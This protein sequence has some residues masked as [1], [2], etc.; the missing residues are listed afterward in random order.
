MKLSQ[1][2]KQ[3]KH[4]EL[5]TMAGKTIYLTNIETLTSEEFGS[6]FKVYFYLEGEPQEPYSSAVFSE[7]VCRT[8]ANLLEYVTVNNLDLALDPCEIKVEKAGKSYILS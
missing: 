1:V 3:P 8:L 4:V 2:V 5:Q 7:H 6:G